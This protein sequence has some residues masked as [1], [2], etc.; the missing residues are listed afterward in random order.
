V[1]TGLLTAYAN[2]H[3]YS[4]LGSTNDI[5]TL[6]WWQWILIAVKSVVH[7]AAFTTFM[8]YFL[9]WSTSWA[10]QHAEEE[11]RNRSRLIDIGRASW[12]LEAVKAAQ[13]SGK[14]MPADLVRE[15]SRNL[16]TTA[17]NS[18]HDLH[19][20]AVSDVLLHGL[21]S[22]PVKAADGSEVDAKRG[23]K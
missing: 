6:P 17:P 20:M 18:D 21:S 2:Y 19:P 1:F 9:R 22:L 3:T 13:D 12:L 7:L 5:A 14:E 8:I 11:F 15:L 16:F 23:S 10:R 4:L